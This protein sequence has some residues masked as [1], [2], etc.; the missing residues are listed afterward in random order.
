M[1]EQRNLVTLAAVLNVN[2][3]VQKNFH[4]RSGERRS[5]SRPTLK[6]LLLGGRRK[7][8]RRQSD[9]EDFIYVDQYHPW[10]MAAIVLLLI[11]SLLDGFFTLY[12]IE[13]GAA[14]KNPIMAYF[15]NFGVWPF[16]TAKFILTCSAILIILV[17]HKYFFHPLGIHVKVIIPA[18]LAVFAV[19]IC[20][21]IYLKYF[22]N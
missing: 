7:S 1:E 9:R 20:W 10:L 22:I 18:S 19:V 11:L 8:P 2:M 12:L 14:E 15:L 13:H 4:E 6:Y 3:P 21:Q 5:Q 16:M 17:F